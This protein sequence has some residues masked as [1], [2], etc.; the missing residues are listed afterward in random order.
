MCHRLVVY[1][2]K[3]LVRLPLAVVP[4]SRFACTSRL[5]VVMLGASVDVVL[6]QL[7]AV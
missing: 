3:K 6:L 5:L 2:N 1:A 4:A 7:V